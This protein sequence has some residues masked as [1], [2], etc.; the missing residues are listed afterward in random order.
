[1][2]KSTLT[3]DRLVPFYPGDGFGETLTWPDLLYGKVLSELEE[4]PTMLKY[5][6][7][8]FLKMLL[9]VLATVIG[10]YLAHQCMAGRFAAG[11]PV[12]LAGAAVDPQNVDANPASREAVKAD[13]TG[14]KGPSDVVNALISAVAIGSIVD[15]TNDEKA[16]PPVDKL[17]E[18]TSVPARLH[19]SVQR[20]KPISR[21]YTIAKPDIAS[22]TVP[23]PERGRAIS[24]RFLST[25]ANSPP[26]ASPPPQETSRDNGVSPPLA[27]GMTESHLAGRV[28]SPIIRTALLLLEPSSLVG[29]AH[30][31]QRRTS[32]DEIPSSSRSTMCRPAR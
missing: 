27:P 31:P 7:K 3:R 15:K 19:R 1:L 12:S 21:T 17:T 4:R 8:L 26:D 29:R 14:S 28:L 13:V 6:S 24:D 32:P 5:A 23:P 9:S 10:S 11:G 30:E 2:E 25:N 22:L 16:A 18:P 20:N